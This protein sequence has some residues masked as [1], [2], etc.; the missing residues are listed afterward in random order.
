MC[1]APADVQILIV[2]AFECS[3][4][5]IDISDLL[6]QYNILGD[7]D[8][9]P[10]A[11]K[12]PPLK[13]RGESSPTYGARLAAWKATPAYAVYAT[14]CD[15]SFSFRAVRMLDGWGRAGAA[16]HAATPGDARHSHYITGEGYK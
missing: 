2:P 8:E 5:G 7:R 10:C 11:P 3:T 14:P 4:D 16:L 6:E 9:L 1:R 13:P 12:Q 15:L